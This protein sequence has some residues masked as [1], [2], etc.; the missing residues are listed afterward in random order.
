[1]KQSVR[2]I[3]AFMARENLDRLLLVILI[4][5]IMSGL[6]VSWLEPDLS[7][8]SAI[9]WAIVTLTTVGYG[10][11]SPATVGGR[12]IAVILMFSGIG[13]LGMLSASLA[14]V[15][16][17]KRL[18]ESRGMGKATLDD[19]IIICEW[20]HRARAIWKELR[21]NAKT[22]EV[23][24]VLVADIDEKPVEDPIFYFVKGEVNDATLE[25]ASL[26]KARTVVVLGDD[27][28]DVTA[29]DA[30]VVLTTLTIESMAPEVYT[31]V[32]LV[33][34]A[35]V[36]HCQRAN[37]DEII[38]GSE[39]SSHLVASATMNHGISRVVSELLST[40]SGGNELYCMAVPPALAG[41]GFLEV[42]VA[43]KEGYQATVVGVQ[44]GGRGGELISNPAV[45]YP[46]TATDYLV[47]IAK[48]RPLLV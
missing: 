40:R 34:T 36:Q 17:S 41:K 43:M 35:N 19:H 45:D 44:K 13:V 39:L 5:V 48:D 3:L 26:A 23:G 16:V 4:M 14:A 20:N 10:D 6:L 2:R 11:I 22:A 12:V 27:S 1:M 38:V 47:F 9:W 33:D 32:E 15:L 31:V 29:R 21:A 42:L 28:L 24:I 8:A 46:V 25:R 7:L 18:R 37:A 30:K